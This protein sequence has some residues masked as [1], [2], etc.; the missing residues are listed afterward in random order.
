MDVVLSA[1]TVWNQVPDSICNAPSV[2][3]FRKDLKTHYFDHLLRPPDG[4]VMSLCHLLLLL[5][6]STNI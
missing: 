5:L 4:S 1:P 6:Y 2:I 3:S